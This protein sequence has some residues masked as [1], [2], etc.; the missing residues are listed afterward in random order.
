MPTQKPLLSSLSSGLSSESA[1]TLVE[2]MVTLAII[3]IVTTV[4]F[5]SF[6]Q[7]RIK[8]RDTKRITDV[9]VLQAALAAY[10]HDE[11]QY[12]TSLVP[13]TALVGP[14][15]G[16]TYLSQIPNNPLPRNDNNCPD[17]D[18][19]YQSLDNNSN[20]LLDF[21]LGQSSSQLPSGQLTATPESITACANAV[22][23]PDISSLCGTVIQSSN[24]GNTRQS[25]GGVTCS[26]PLS[27]NGG[28]VANQCGCTTETD[29]QFCARLGATCGS[30]SATDNCG[31]ARTVADC[32]SCGANQSC[33]NHACVAGLI[34]YWKLDEA[35]STI[36]YDSSGQGNNGNFVYSG[37][38]PT[39]TMGKH[40]S[41]LNL[42]R[43][44]GYGY[45]DIGDQSV[46]DFG[47][48]DWTISAWLKMTN[49]YS[50]WN[51]VA[52]SKWNNGG[53]TG[54]N[55][56]SIGFGGSGASDRYPFFGIESSST[57]YAAQIDTQA[58]I[59]Q[60]YQ[61]TGVRQGNDILLYVNGTLA[62][63][64]NALGNR[65]V[66]NAGRSLF[67]GAFYNGGTRNSFAGI[68][69]DV[70]LYNHALSAQEI[71]D[72]YNQPDDQDLAGFNNC[73]D[74][75][76][77][78]SQSY[79]TIQIGTQCWMA[80]NMNI[81]T[82]VTGTTTQTNNGIVEKYCYSDNSANCDAEG[83]LYQWAEAVQYINGASN[84]A[85]WSPTPTDNI[86]GICPDGWHLPSDAEQDIL[87]QYLTVPPNTCSASRTDWGCA[88]A[89]T[90]LKDASGFNALISGYRYENGSFMNHGIYT[91]FWS[92]GAVSTNTAWFRYLAPGYSGVN[93]NSY[94][95]AYGYSVRCL[96]N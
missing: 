92:S 7:A 66:N 93:R 31:Q 2:I 9:H 86:Q 15:S 23:T 14:V 6:N 28:G 32:G 37:A 55:E 94:S 57:T 27:C 18:Y 43:S 96:K 1:F 38:I 39:W 3:A 62:T 64:T 36:A 77:Y 53:A 47:A 46:Y 52:I 75:G 84:T 87:D 35:T 58:N 51:G 48:A 30:L 79:P 80:K 50:G 12:P 68:V 54:T 61:L 71:L 25:L 42:Y 16:K 11:G 17:Q 60:W 20:Y 72:L 90:T 63:S 34:G 19:Q 73:G 91:Y 4:S 33:L 41:A 26:A 88:T 74:T 49:S 95:R 21:C 22:W 13:G 82:M 65:A 70:R 69:D 85:N 83:G 24:C 59:N 10:Y 78:Y 67:I 44:S 45:V 81:G 40:N 29:T 56:W 76:T 8:G 5:V 89:G